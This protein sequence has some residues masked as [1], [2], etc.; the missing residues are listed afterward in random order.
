[1][2]CFCPAINSEQAEA[3]TTH[4]D[5]KR[6]EIFEVYFRFFLSVLE[7]KK[8]WRAYNASVLDCTVFSSPDS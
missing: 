2:L 6:V 7:W 3:W 4:L 1:M 5:F 8:N